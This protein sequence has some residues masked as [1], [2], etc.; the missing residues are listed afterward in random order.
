M[1]KRSYRKT[2]G[3]Q[4]EEQRVSLG[5][6]LRS[7]LAHGYDLLSFR[8]DVLAGTVV[9]IVALPLSM[10]LAIATGVPPQHGLYTAIIAGGFVA[11]LGGSRFQVTGTTATYIVI[12]A[13]I[14]AK[15]GLSGLLTTGLLAGLLL[16]GMGFA[17]LGRFIQFI[18]H[19]V[20]TGFTAG[21]AT[22]IAC[23]QIKD[24]LGL[25]VSKLPV[26]FFGQVSTYW[27]ARAT[28]S[29]I[30]VAVT[31]STFA[32]LLYVPKVFKKIPSPLVAIGFVAIVAA[33]ARHFFPEIEVATLGSR[34]QTTI[35]GKVFSGI[36]AFAPRPMLPW[37]E[38]GL[39][40]ALIRELF[41]SAFAIAMLGAIETLL[42]A[43]IADGMTGEKHEPNAE[44][45]ALGAG[46]VVVPFFGGIAASGVLARTATN[47]RSGART[48]FAAVA[49]SA[50][51]LSAI[52]LFAPLIAYV[53]MASLAALLVV[54][55]WNMSEVRH[56]RHILQVAPRG[57]VVILLACYLL[58]V[59]F[60]MVVSVTAGVVLAA[61]LFMRRMAELT[62]IEV[63]SPGQPSK[64][65]RE[66]PKGVAVYR[67]EGPLFF[68]AAQ[69]AMSALDAIGA[70]IRVVI[71]DLAKVP[72]IDATGL[73]ALESALDRLNHQKRF[74][75]LAGPL[76]EPRSIFDK[77]SLD[78]HHENVIVAES[79]DEAIRTADD[80]FMLNP[81]WRAGAAATVTPSPA[82]VR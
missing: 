72:V 78:D 27:E 61:V 6:A 68:G 57:D 82:S 16:M 36:P 12:L 8:A 22:I 33:L 4:L 51:V 20:T 49:H 15:Y 23:L 39:S 3:A 63:H 69:N 60:D 21:I 53:P 67:I 44:L 47:V 17:R 76:P 81:S 11:L 43:V 25:N 58:T 74:L 32:L 14:A 35:G 62:A 18:P 30:E 64:L 66:L 41:P 26:D 29:W 19:P 75:I 52:L 45:V 50:V 7:S 34:F 38:T 42:S 59:V 70:D 5:V 24:A 71:L 40:I 28:I 65:A 77:A 1:P 9:G 37:G 73:V 80:L 2:V 55:A 54:V 10:A 31:L 46:N 48:P 13:P 79:L 56:F